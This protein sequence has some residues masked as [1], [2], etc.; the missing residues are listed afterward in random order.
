MG[1]CSL[2]VASDRTG[3][4]EVATGLKG[5]CHCY[6]SCTAQVVV[7]SQW[8][9][10]TASIA[11]VARLVAPGGSCPRLLF[12]VISAG[13]GACGGQTHQSCYEGGVLAVWGSGLRSHARDHVFMVV[14][15]C[16]CGS[17]ASGGPRN[18]L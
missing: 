10:S 13:R 17:A 2:L 11:N 14:P 12:E 18:G 3:R 9:S 7:I 4:V 16:G 15:F 6:L 5:V 8:S 1:F